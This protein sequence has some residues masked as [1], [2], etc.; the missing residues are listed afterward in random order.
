[1]V[2]KGA[3]ALPAIR[4]HYQKQLQA[5]LKPFFRLIGSSKNKK[6]IRPL[7]ARD[8]FYTVTLETIPPKNNVAG[9]SS[10]TGL[11][12]PRRTEN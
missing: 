9:S 7:S 1:M 10:V 4:G 6:K 3:A 11:K 5:G 2:T 12:L 8:G